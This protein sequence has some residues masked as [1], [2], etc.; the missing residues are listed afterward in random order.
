MNMRSS[1]LLIVICAALAAAAT[2]PAFG[3][4]DP[5]NVRLTA[6]ASEVSPGESFVVKIEFT[7]E[8]P[9]HIYG[10]AEAMG[11]KTVVEMQPVPGLTFSPPEFPEPVKKNLP[12]LGGELRVYQGKMTVTVP[13]RVEPGAQAK[14]RDLVALVGYGACDDKTCLL[15]VS[16][17]KVTGSVVVK[18]AAEPGHEA[19]PGAQQGVGNPEGTEP[20]PAT[21]G[22]GVSGGVQTAPAPAA[23]SGRAGED[24]L[25]SALSHGLLLALLMS[26]G[27]GVLG[28]LTPCVYP[29]I[30]VTIGIFAA[31][32]QA[33]A[34]RRRTIA[35]ALVYVL[36]ITICYTALGV[37]AALLGRD[38]GQFMVNPWVIGVVVAIFSALSLSMFGLYE[39]NLP[40]SV[41]GKLSTAGGQGYIG[42]LIMGLVLGFVAA[43]C[44]GPF[45]ASILAYIATKGS[46]II[47]GL[48]LFVFG[49]GLGMLFLVLAISAGSISALPKSGEWMVTVKTVSGF[50]ILVMALYFLSNVVGAHVIALLGAGLAFAFATYAGAFTSLSSEDGFG[51]K[52]GK[53]VGIIAAIVGAY[54]LLGALAERGF[55]VG[56]LS[57]Q[58][59]QP[60]EAVAWE[61]DID[62]AFVR[63][64]A[65]SKPLFADFTADWCIPC[66]Q[67]EQQVF[68]DA[69]VAAELAGFV[70]VRLDCTDI[71]SPHSKLKTQ[72]YGSLA[73]PYLAVWSAQDAADQ[74]KRLKPTAYHEGYLHAEEFL[75]LLREARGP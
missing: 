29:M 17:R 12:A 10:P 58:G 21:D 52:F 4:G 3:Q 71:E 9:Y 47:G 43:P 34:G 67:M 33:G 37:V 14:R 15:P 25:K 26:F 65:E 42:A 55:V 44:V 19:G 75:K 6:S 50:L 59:T 40:T 51:R 32:S 11:T 39:I 24:P 30:P 49:L 2:V 48:A 7:I 60:E 66:K 70:V 56:P 64:A 41:M 8:A 28:S 72:G 18:A 23:N 16:A 31:Q 45:A 73:M 5:V 20:G 61:E 46:L 1:K 68:P 27:W 62:S 69:R 74:G 38:I 13:A 22:A 54:L 57:V 63:A 35:L 53:A 36:G